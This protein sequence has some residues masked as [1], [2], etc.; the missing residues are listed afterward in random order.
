MAKNKIWLNFGVPKWRDL[1]KNGCKNSNFNH[2]RCIDEIFGLG[3]YEEKIKFDEIRGYRKGVS[4]SNE[5]AKIQT[6]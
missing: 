2:L 4:P 3:K 6:F 1:L 5:D